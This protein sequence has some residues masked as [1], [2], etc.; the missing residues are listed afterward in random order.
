MT[1]SPI[2][3]VKPTKVGPMRERMVHHLQMDW[4]GH[5][6]TSLQFGLAQN[7]QTKD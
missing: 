1:D 4:D 5:S 6:R 7:E 2:N 3:S